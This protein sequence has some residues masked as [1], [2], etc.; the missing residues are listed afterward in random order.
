MVSKIDH[1]F[2]EMFDSV[3]S[4]EFVSKI[5]DP[6]SNQMFSVDWLNEDAKKSFMKGPLKTKRNILK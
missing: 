1:H 5:K 4:S 2:G 6:V 3:L